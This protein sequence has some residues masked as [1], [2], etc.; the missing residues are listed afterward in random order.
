MGN[1]DQRT[2]TPDDLKIALRK[3]DEQVS[4]GVARTV[5]IDIYIHRLLVWRS[6]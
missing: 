1:K 6:G 3:R 5:I 4:C 2:L